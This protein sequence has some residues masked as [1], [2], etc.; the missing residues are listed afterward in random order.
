ML[1][2]A[3]PSSALPGYI[4]R[5]PYTCRPPH[6]CCPC[7]PLTVCFHVSSHYASWQ[8]DRV[9]ERHRDY[10]TVTQYLDRQLIV[11]QVDKR[12]VEEDDQMTWNTQSCV[13]QLPI[14]FLILCVPPHPIAFFFFFNNPA[15]PEISPLPLPAPL[16]I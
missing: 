14:E 5:L 8:L 6:A 15:P 2:S 13:E 1:N 16:P 11:R 7:P 9:R 4:K 12:I 3:L 10:M